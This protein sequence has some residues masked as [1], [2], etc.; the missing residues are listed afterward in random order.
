MIKKKLID[1]HTGERFNTLT[2]I[3]PKFKKDW[4]AMFQESLHIIATDRELNGYT[5]RVFLELMSRLNF[6]NYV[7]IS[8]SEIGK[9]IGIARP[10]VNTAISLLVEKQIIFKQNGIGTAKAYKLN[11]NI[12]WK[13]DVTKFEKEK[14]KYPQIGKKTIPELINELDQNRNNKNK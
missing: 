5:L 13:G 6:E 4:I 12:G 1:Q 11:P 14:R 3:N 9:S 10:N 8:Q 2:P 7:C